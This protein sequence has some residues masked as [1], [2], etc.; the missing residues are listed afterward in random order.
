MAAI[1]VMSGFF[2]LYRHLGSLALEEA[3]A[4][5]DRVD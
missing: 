4:A 2:A 3:L 5:S 1:T